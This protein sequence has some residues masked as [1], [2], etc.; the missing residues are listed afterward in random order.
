LRGVC[1]GACFE[2]EAQRIMKAKERLP[3]ADVL[4]IAAASAL[5]PRTV[6]RAVNEGITPRSMAV[7]EA[8]VS[9]LESYGFRE[10][11]ERVRKGS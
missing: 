11:A 9:A 7:R 2:A 5:D 10:H 1:V 6:D 4:R 3:R 8:I